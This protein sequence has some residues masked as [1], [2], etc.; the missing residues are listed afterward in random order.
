M[1]ELRVQPRF[2][3]SS[4]QISAFGVTVVMELADVEFRLRQN[5]L[6]LGQWI[7]FG[8]WARIY[9]SR[10]LRPR[11]RSGLR[12]HGGLF[13]CQTSPDMLAAAGEGAILAGRRGPLRQG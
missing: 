3:L 10:N 7:I 13:G 2:H 11:I 1:L 4:N 5:P 12:L 9:S 8:R 6:G